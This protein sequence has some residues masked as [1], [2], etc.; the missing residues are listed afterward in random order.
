M[1]IY[2]KILGCGS[3][4]PTVRRSATAQ[5][6]KNYEKLFLIDCAENTQVQLRKYSVKFAVI[7]NIFISHLHGDHFFGLFGLLSSFSLMG[8]TKTLNI[9]AHDNLRKMLQ[10]DCSPVKLDELDFDI[11]FVPLNFDKPNQIFEN[12]HL[13]VTSFPLRH[14]IP[15]C[16][17]LFREKPSPKNIIKEAVLKYNLSIASIVKIK[18]G[19][20]YITPQ[21]VVIPNN[22][23]TIEPVPPACYAFVSDTLP[24]DYVSQV[25]KDVDLLYHEATYDNSLFAR[26]KQTFHT[27]AADAAK[28]AL[29]ANVGKL[30]LG[31]Y[32][33][34][35]K[36]VSIIENQAREIFPQSFAVQDGMEFLI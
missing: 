11:N 28:I 31:H 13:T 4:L 1:S 27:V 14:R 34:R 29:N 32:S 35:Y 7:D 24:L 8:R 3:A 2:L 5:I 20:D 22:Q 23:L 15:C 30:L 9:F 18:N 36:D 25:V 10:S 12:K 33:N 26:S 17:F 16:G 19:E 6:L 21:G